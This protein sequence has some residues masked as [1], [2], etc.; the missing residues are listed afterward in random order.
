M[1][2][3]VLE[4][5]LPPDLP[6]N[7]AADLVAHLRSL[8][9][10]YVTYLISFF[11]LATQWRATI[12]LRHAGEQV[13]YAALRWWLVYL[14]FITGVPFSSSVVGHYGDLP[15]AVWLYAANMIIVGALSLPLRL[16]EIAPEHSVRA[17]VSRAKA[18][19]FM[20]TALASV[21]ISLVAPGYAMYAYML[22]IIA[23]PLTAWWYRPEGEA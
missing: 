19:F 7:N 14:F 6:I 20:L 3:L 23:G 21:L 2:L 9:P 1:T 12:E 15:P 17:R 10:E 5:R 16:M 18:L 22:N 4:I 11:V 8:Q 13:S